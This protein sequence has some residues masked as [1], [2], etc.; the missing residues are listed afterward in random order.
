MTFVANSDDKEFPVSIYQIFKATWK[1]MDDQDFELWSGATDPETLISTDLDGQERY[2]G[3]MGEADD[4]NYRL[5]VYD[6]ETDDWWSVALP[7]DCFPDH[8]SDE[9]AL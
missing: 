9:S 8:D 5:D 6:A 3:L 4:G 7:T 2:I 1:P